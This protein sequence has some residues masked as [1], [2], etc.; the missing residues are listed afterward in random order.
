M[1]P[2]DKQAEIELDTVDLEEYAKQKKN[3]PK[4]RVYVIRVDKK[5]YRVE[6]SSM[7]GRQILETAGRDPQKFKLLQIMHSG[8][9][10]EVP[11]ERTVDF[12]TPGIE[13]FET[14]PIIS[15]EG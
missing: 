2:I 4:A 1:V 7:T 15:T 10:D 6:A 13:S 5:K 3:P 8:Q 14:T 9:T 11:P 12:T